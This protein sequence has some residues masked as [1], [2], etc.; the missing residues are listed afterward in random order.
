MSRKSGRGSKRRRSSL[1]GSRALKRQNAEVTA[2]VQPAEA[3]GLRTP[4]AEAP[5][6]SLAMQYG[7]DL[8]GRMDDLAKAVL[9][10]GAEDAMDPLRTALKSV[11]ERALV[12]AL[13]GPA[14][15]GKSFSIVRFAGL[16]PPNAAGDA[17][18]LLP[19]ASTG[20]SVT[21]FPTVI[22]ASHDGKWRLKLY[23]SSPGA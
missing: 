2:A 15:T 16:M 20:V 5:S 3:P 7:K 13:C 12:V 8:V 1:A 23:K 17:N 10:A 22:Q 4:A 19:S 18:V 21:S 14:G 6:H 11:Q 9:G